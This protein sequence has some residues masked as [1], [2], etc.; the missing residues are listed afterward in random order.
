MEEGGAKRL[1]KWPRATHRKPG[2]NRK[3]K[4]KRD[5]GGDTAGGT[6]RQAHLDVQKRPRRKRK[7]AQI[8]M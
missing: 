4:R 2:G 8:N 5:G 1:R 6:R 3:G 7:G